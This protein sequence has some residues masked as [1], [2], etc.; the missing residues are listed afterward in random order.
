MRSF[1]LVAAFL[2][3]MLSGCATYEIRSTAIAKNQPLP[4]TH[5][6]VALQVINNA[7][8]LAPLHK[9]WTAV[10]VVRTD[11][12]DAIKAAAIAQAKEKAEKKGKTID[13][14][15]VDW[16][17]EVYELTPVYQG[18][19]DSQLFIGSMPPGEYMIS[20][21]Y[22]FYNSGDMSSWISMPVFSA[23]GEFA[24]SDT[25]LTDLGSVLF[26]P[27]L[28]IKESSF[29]STSTS[30]KAFVT[31]VFEESDLGSIVLP[32]YPQ[33]QQQLNGKAS[34][35]WKTDELDPLREKLSVLA[36]EN[37]LAASPIV[38]PTTQ[39]RALAAKF[40][41]LAIQQDGS[42]TTHNLPTNSQ[43]YA[44]LQIDGKVAVGGELG[45]LFV[46][47]DWQ[48]WQLTKPVDADE[49]IVWMG[50][51]ADSY[52]ALTSSA[53][54][55]QVYR[56]NQLN[57]PWQK[58]G[59]YVKK[60]PN[61]W[62]VQ[63]G[64]LFAAI[65]QQGTLRIFNDNKRH[66]YNPADNS[67]STDKS[68]SLRNM[69]QLANGALVAVEVSQWDGVG[70]QLISVD[71]GLTWQSINRNLSLFGDIKADVSLPVLTDNNEVITLSRN[72]K[73]SGEKSQIRIATTA[74]SN[75]D[76]SSSW[77]LHGVA[78]DNCHSL[79][80]QLTTDNTLY[81]LCDQGQIVSTS[82]F[83]ETWQ[84]DIDRDIAQMQAQYE[85]FIDELK[86]QQ[87]VEEKAKETQA[88]AASEE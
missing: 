70:S 1:L 5:G 10:I 69:A 35:S 67:W 30:S 42:W 85:T 38:L 78:K 48:Q 7:E 65:T 2:V 9:G 4:A 74:L 6:V 88:E 52:F 55:Y 49:A 41:R 14:D 16:D 57:T 87:E 8:R 20:T 29:W 46:S 47:S 72:R 15:K 22:S 76:D 63:N 86:Q 21:L 11:N 71:D 68:T 36:T 13:E 51:T 82:D 81:F 19:V 61:D 33:I 32:Q 25:T 80:P 31:R 56:F 45:Q 64:G 23:A 83:G 12:M 77:Q 58:V 27:L 73:S 59:S 17:P 44:A 34:Q 60:D 66:D 18:T 79:L 84:T 62:L 43:L 39:Q 75:A 40:G 37:A 54:Q 50:Q 26:Q 24:V 28:S 3:S 53:K